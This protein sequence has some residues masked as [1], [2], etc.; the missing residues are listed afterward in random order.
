M[1]RIVSVALLVAV[2]TMTVSMAAAGDRIKIKREYYTPFG[3]V[4]VKEYHYPHHYRYP[5]H[6]YYAS[7]CRHYPPRT[8]YYNPHHPSYPPAPYY[9][10]Y[11]HYWGCK[12]KM[13]D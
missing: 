9:P 13:D 2:A 5:Y 7:H 8:Y 4:K 3:K 12:I 1:K 11:P 6:P 10:P